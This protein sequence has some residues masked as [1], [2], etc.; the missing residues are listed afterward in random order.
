MCTLIFQWGNF[1]TTETFLPPDGVDCQSYDTPG[2]FYARGYAEA[3]MYGYG[4]YVIGGTFVISPQSR[5]RKSEH[6]LKWT[7]CSDGRG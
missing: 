5:L 3:L 4:R 6:G 2:H 1:V 7:G